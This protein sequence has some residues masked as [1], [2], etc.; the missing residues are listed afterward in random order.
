MDSPRI[1]THHFDNIPNDLTT[2]NRWLAY[3]LEPKPNKPGEFTKPPR[4]VH[5]GKYCDHTVPASWATFPQ[6]V[7]YYQQHA[8]IDGVGFMLTGDDDISGVDFDD[9]IDDDGNVAAW[10]QAHVDELDSYTEISPSGR[11]LRIF[12]RGNLPPGKRRSGNVEMY[13]CD[14]YLTVTGNHLPGTPTTINERT[15]ALGRVHRRVFGA[16]RQEELPQEKRAQGAATRLDDDDLLERMFNSKRGAEI[17]ALW[18]GDTS[19]YGGDHSKADFA[20]CCHLRFWTG[21]DAVTID[22]IFR[23]SGL[24]R[25]KWER[26]DYRTATIE[27]AIADTRNTYS[28]AAPD[29]TAQLVF[30][31]DSRVTARLS[32]RSPFNLFDY[33]AEDGGILDAWLALHGDG[34]LFVT[35]YKSWYQRQGTHWQKDERRGVERQLQQLLNNMNR[36]AKAQLR[37]ATAAKDEELV[38]VLKAYVGATKRTKG[39]IASVESMAQAQRAV[40]AAE[41][42]S[43]NVLNLRNGTLDLDTLE[44][45]PHRCEDNLTYCLPYDY[46]PAA[47]CPRFERF[48]TEILVKEGTTDPDLDLCRLVAE[49]MGYSLTNDTSQEAMAWMVGEEGG[50][51]KT[52]F[53]KTL[54]A[55]LGP[56][57][58]SIDFQRIGAPGDY[59]LAEIPGRRIIFSTESERGGKVVESYIKRIVSGETIP[60]RPIYGTP[61]DF[62]PVAKIWWAMNDRPV[63]KDTGNSMWRRMKLIPFYRVFTDNDKDPDL[64]GKLLDELPGILNFA[65]RGLVRLR[66]N[67]RFAE[68]AAVVAA[69]DEYK[70]ES[71]PVAQWV[72]ERTVQGDELYTLAT[73]LL[74]DYSA[75]TGGNNRYALN[76]TNFGTELRKLK[77]AKRR[78]KRGNAYNL[79]LLT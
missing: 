28:G 70:R 76:N 39:R 14:R 41:L 5:T 36:E 72:E 34:W 50:N 30:A 79:G 59:Q 1:V 44:L 55:L 25:A 73:D 62:P 11:G 20:L 78:E 2:K 58:K 47:V 71:N 37:A 6:G 35:G 4:S 24:Y 21:G 29:P 7:S 52:V 65:I 75:W 18:N 9:C 12:T 31:D 68:S 61:F 77:I 40:G 23:Q 64:I 38:K 22:R 74:R 48:I 33:A 19:G 13:D 3:C 15:D 63:I 42:D 53:I 16:D 32:S 67:G 10:A 66:Q 27:R 57:A 45:H 43:G 69:V 56:L 49:L 51:G 54:E 46:D 8:E 17:Q 60:A 26:E